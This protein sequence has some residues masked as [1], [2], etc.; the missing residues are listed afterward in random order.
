M[1]SWGC[2]ISLLLGICFISCENESQYLFERIPPHHSGIHFSNRITESDSI[3]VLVNEYIYNGGGLGLADFNQD[4]LLDVYMSGNMVPNAL[5]LNKGNFEFKEITKEAGVANASHW[6]AGISLVDINQDGWPDIYVAATNR[7]EISHRRNSLFINQGLNEEGVPVFID[8][9]KEYGLGDTSYTTQTA[10]FDYDRDGDLD[11]FLAANAMMAKE[12]PN[13][14]KRK[15]KKISIPRVDKL[16]RNE[17]TDSLGHPFFIDVSGEAGITIEGYSLGLNIVDINRDGWKDIFISNDYVSND[18]LYI[19]QKDGSFEDQ[20]SQYF[21]HTSHSA[22]GNDVVDFNADGKVDIICLD[23]LPE[24]NYRRKTMMQPNNYNSYV[25]NERYGYDFQYVRN[26]FQVNQGALNDSTSPRFAEIGMYAGIAA[27]DWSWAPLAADF[28]NDGYRDLII[29]NGFPK[30]ITDRDF[31]DYYS[32]VGPYAPNSLLLSKIPSA[33]L[34]NYAYQNQG[35]LTFEDMTTAWG[36]GISSFSNGAAYGDLDNDGDLDYIVNNINDSAFVYRNTLN[37]R[38]GKKNNW[39]R[40]GLHG[41][42]SNKNGVGTIVELKAGKLRQQFEYNVSRGYLSS[43]EPFMHFG[44]GDSKKVEELTVIWPDGKE[45]RLTNI[46]PNQLL[47]LIYAQAEFPP[48]SDKL[49][50]EPQQIFHEITDEVGLDFIHAEVDFIDF[51]LQPMLPHKLSQYGPALAVSDV[52]GDGLEDV[53]IGASRSHKGQFALQQKDGSFRLRDLFVG[54]DLGEKEGEELGV[55]FF[56][57]DQDGDEDLYVVS[58]GNELDISDAS[59]QDKFY[60]NERGRFL[61]QP[62]ALPQFLSSGSC[63]KAADYDKDGD[64]DLFLGTRLQPHQYPLSVSSY[65]LKNESSVQGVKFV[66]DG[67]VAPLLDKIGLVSDALWTDIDDNGSMDLLIAGEW[68]PLTLL[69]NTEGKFENI[70]KEA[71][72]G[73]KVGWWNSLAAGDFDRDGDID[74]IAGNQGQNSLLRA[75]EQYPVKSY[76]ADFDNN[77]GLDLILA[78]Y[79]PKSGSDKSLMEVPY[80]GRIDFQK[81]INGIR[82]DY[83]YH[84]AFAE[85]SI[86]DILPKE[87]GGDYWEFAANYFQTSYI[88]N[89]GNGKFAIHPLPMEAQWAPVYGMLVE[90]FDGDALLDVLMLGNDFGTEI[91]MG[92]SDAFNGLL[93]KGDGKGGFQ[94]L[95]LEKSGFYV[96]GDAKSLVRL[97]DEEGNTR[98]FAGQNSDRLKIFGQ[99]VA[100]EYLA[101]EPLEVF[102]YFYHADGSKQ[103]WELGYGTSFLSQSSRSIQVPEGVQKVEIHSM[104]GKK[105]IV[106]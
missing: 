44:L 2:L 86:S 106:E 85:A 62:E 50:E 16:F 102:G 69:K 20:A 9:A 3:N 52:N 87:K 54:A 43:V 91:S 72:L 56:D 7:A 57:A 5:Y 10:F 60:L 80:F 74:Y 42:A 18:I 24:D 90:D 100:S 83:L 32:D 99:R 4:G 28:D 15:H 104:L 17:G 12:Q 45:Q 89:L 59:Y 53:Y 58:G 41:P 81:Q 25:N 37:E 22:M 31:I 27:T 34:K 67:E 46:S 95:S 23:M 98:I 21:K 61:Y 64:L 14:Y 103:I 105:R 68:M 48:E 96:P 71:D 33:K 40:V 49:E 6:S 11:V 73:Q 93:L 88:E 35:D 26:T 1:K 63:I 75:S 65:I 8:M 79:L 101:L 84:A 30:D 66:I 47:E 55:L 19:N 70:T 94:A 36:I 92:R 39:L 51:N 82:Q 38:E 78:S 13:K 29:T 97:S 76:A 77:K